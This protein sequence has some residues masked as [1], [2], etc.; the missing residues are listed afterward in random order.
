METKKHTLHSNNLNGNLVWITGLS[1]AG[2]T[3]LANTLKKN[4]LSEGHKPI[5]LDG[6]MLREI[7][8][9]KYKGYSLEDRKKLSFCYARLANLL[10]NQGFFVIVATISMFESVRNWNR[11]NNCKYCEVYLKVNRQ[12]RISRDS[13]K[14]YELNTELVEIEKGFDEP[15][16]PDIIFDNFYDLDKMVDEIK[17]YLINQSNE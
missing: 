3:T 9:L 15:K 5:L 16:K 4:M 13:K 7:L 17:I 1:G 2:K 14:I 11:E 10:V 12:T 6:D 8:G